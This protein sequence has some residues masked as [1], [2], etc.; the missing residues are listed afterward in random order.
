MRETRSTSWIWRLAWVLIRIALLAALG[1][2]S[3]TFVYEQF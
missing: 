2:T 3:S 1:A